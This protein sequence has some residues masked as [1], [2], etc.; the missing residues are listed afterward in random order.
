[1]KAQLTTETFTMKTPDGCRFFTSDRH[2]IQIMT[3]KFEEMLVIVR[4]KCAELGIELSN[5]R[6]IVGEF[7][8]SGNISQITELQT[9]LIRENI[10]NP[11]IASS[12]PAPV[13]Q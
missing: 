5:E 1:M 9:Q 3:S 6:P 7:T 12:P 2:E 10:L 4:G 8:V 11:P 13:S